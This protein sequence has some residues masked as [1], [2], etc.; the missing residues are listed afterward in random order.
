MAHETNIFYSTFS[1]PIGPL[2]AVKHEAGVLNIAFGD[3]EK[4]LTPIGLWLRRMGLNANRLIRDDDRLADVKSQLEEY[5]RGNRKTFT[6]PLDLKGTPF[7]KA[8]WNALLEIPY[9]ET[10]SYKQIA[11]R[12]NMPRAVRAI[13]GANH[14]NPIPILVP[15]HRVIGS[16]GE[17][18]GYGGGLSIKEK[19]LHLE[20]RSHYLKAE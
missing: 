3:E 15:C 2:T 16:N 4:A 19:L 11:L 18:I 6:L 17:L 13:G 7:Q 9:G 14:D 12:L 5:F 1:T 8:V 10:R 20:R